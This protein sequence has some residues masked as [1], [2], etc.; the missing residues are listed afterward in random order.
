MRPGRPLWLYPCTGVLTARLVLYARFGQR[1]DDTG[2]IR[3]S[4][5]SGRVCLASGC[6]AILPWEV[7]TQLRGGPEL[8]VGEL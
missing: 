5:L 1:A 7:D 3:E 2:E 4:G 6:L 8:C